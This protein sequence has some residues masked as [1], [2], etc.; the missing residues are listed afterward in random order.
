MLLDMTR[1]EYAFVT[2]CIQIKSDADK[3]EQKKIGQLLYSVD[4]LLSLHQRSWTTDPCSNKPGQRSHDQID[5]FVLELLD[6]VEV[7]SLGCVHG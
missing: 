7:G 3:E 1:E 5:V 4:S 6:D 2:A